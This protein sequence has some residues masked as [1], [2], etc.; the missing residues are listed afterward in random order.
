VK[1]EIEKPAG[2]KLLGRSRRRWKGNNKVKLKELMF[3]V[4]ERTKSLNPGVYYMHH[5]SEH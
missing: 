1:E 3:K 4:K 2:I 5:N